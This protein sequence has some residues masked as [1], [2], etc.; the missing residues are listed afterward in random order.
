MAK[1]IASRKPNQCR[2]YHQ[3]MEKYYQSVGN[4]VRLLSTSLH[5]CSASQPQPQP[6]YPF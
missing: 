4:I 1:C 6:R 3:K 2:L 5:P